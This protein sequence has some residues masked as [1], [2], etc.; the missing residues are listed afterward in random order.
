MSLV[1]D[2]G[3]DVRLPPTRLRAS[4]EYATALLL[5]V[6]GAVVTWFRVPGDHRDRVW[7]EDANIFLVQAIERGPWSVIL[8][9][10]AGYQHFVPRFVVA[11][12]YPY[13]D[14]ASY[15][16]LVFA[17]C[18]LITGAAA[19]AVF[20]LSRDL[21]PWWPARVG[22]AAV[23]VLLPLA[24]QETVGNL[25][26]IHTYAMWL[27]PWLLL[28]RPRTW[29]SSVGW[30]VVTFAATLTEIQS[31]FFVFL[32]A[33]GLRRADRR[34][35]PVFA[36][37]LVAGTIQVLTSLFVQ[38]TT[39]EG[40]LSVGSTVMGWMINTVMPLVSA[41]PQTIRQWVIESGMTSALLILIPIAAAM[42]VTLIWGTANQ[43]LL[44]I[45]MMLGSAATYTGSAWANSG[46]W[47]DYAAEPLADVGIRLAVNIRYG[48]ASGMM[49]VA[50]MF[51]AAAVARRRW[52]GSRT[53]GFGALVV[54]TAVVGVLALGATTAISIRDRV[55]RWSPAVT[56]AARACGGLPADGTVT[57][58]VAPDRS[59][60]LACSDVLSLHPR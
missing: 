50:V 18:S 51:V 34:K 22:A 7:A 30:A 14:L 49:L 54:C 53:V 10:Y 55:D 4:V 5:T 21:I 52:A 1:A 40:P 24:T 42:L 38:R 36:A 47:F 12:I 35:I 28:Y 58:P 20:W 56:D 31:V 13:F 15:P 33:F 8:E 48:V 57:L 32:L 45:T 41:D 37:F 9:G 26:D 60:D 59:V 39:G 23:T 43:R 27:T 44:A 29:G 19:A 3:R 2:S 25:A 11:L 17:I 6:A 16:V 46:F